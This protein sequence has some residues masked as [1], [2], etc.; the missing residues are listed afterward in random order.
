M[1]EESILTWVV[2]IAIP[3]VITI[4][5][6]Y[7]KLAKDKRESEN[8]LTKMESEIEDH[9]E[10]LNDIKDEQKQQ[11]EDLKI[12]GKLESQNTLML[13]MIK[14][15]KENVYKSHRVD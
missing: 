13:D 4:G 15:L 8:R 10:S 3:F 1:T 6:F 14:E 2:T 12:L 9:K 5:G 7:M 11:R